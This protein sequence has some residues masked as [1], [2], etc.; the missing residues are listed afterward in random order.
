MENREKTLCVYGTKK[1]VPYRKME[2][3]ITTFSTPS[4]PA[5]LKTLIYKAFSA[6]VSNEELHQDYTIITSR[7]HHEQIRSD[8]GLC[9]HSDM[10][11]ISVNKWTA[12]RL[13]IFMA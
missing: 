8:R 1:R 2:L 9:V 11:R 4:A 6:F 7:L 5:V 13:Q 10:V 12:A 3:K